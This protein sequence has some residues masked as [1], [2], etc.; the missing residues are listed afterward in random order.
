MEALPREDARHQSVLGAVLVN[1][2]HDFKD[3]ILAVHNRFKF[4]HHI[5]RPDKWQSV[6]V[7]QAAVADMAEILDVSFQVHPYRTG[8]DLWQEDIQPNLPWAEDHFQ[9]RVG[10]EPL[11]P[12]VQ[13]A[14]WPWA[15]SAD[16]FRTNGDKF[17]H[18]YMERY[19]PKDAGYPTCAVGHEGIRYAYGDLNDV[20]DH[21]YK[22]PLS[23]QAYLPVWFP[24]DTGVVHGERV[25]CTLGYH[26]IVRRDKLHCTYYIRSCDIYRHFRDD[27][28]LSSRLQEWVLGR[29][30]ALSPHWNTIHIGN[31]NFH[32]VSLHCFRGDYQKLFKEDI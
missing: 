5:I 9:E 19:W 3:A 16:K 25:P 26:F 20:V 17:S 23:R 18:T 32:C 8:K 2:H 7:P 1:I 27:L 31:F 24:E 15:L 29:L 10:Y 6:K 4:D 11:N 12:G 30:Q 13:W 14:N 21:L 22:D 28:Y